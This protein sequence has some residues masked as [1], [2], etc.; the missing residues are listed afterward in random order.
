MPAVVSDWAV[1]AVHGGG[2]HLPSPF[3]SPDVFVPAGPDEPPRRGERE[4]M[5]SPVVVS[6]IRRA[7]RRKP[8]SSEPEGDDDLYIENFVK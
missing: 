5:E 1:A 4:G 8:L 6:T 7:T 3:L 2:D